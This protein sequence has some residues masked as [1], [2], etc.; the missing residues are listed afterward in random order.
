MAYCS[1]CGFQ[2]AGKVAFC[3][4][5]GTAVNKPAQ[6]KSAESSGKSSSIQSVSDSIT[7][8]LGLDRIDSFSLSKF[9]SEVF[10]KHDPAEVERLISVGTAETTPPLNAAMGVMPN[11]WIFFRALCGTIIAYLIFVIAWNSYH[12]LN[13]VPGLIVIGSLAVPF[14]ILILFF[15]LNTP[16]N[17]SIVRIVQLFLIGGAISLL[18]TLILFAQW[19]F[20]VTAFGASAA[21]IIEEIGK[22]AALLF[23]IRKVDINR[24]QYRL[25]AL[26]LGAAVGAGFAAFESAGYA[27]RVGLQMGPAAMLDMIMFRGILAPFMHI[28]WTAI[29][30]SAFWIARRHHNT[31]FQTV[32][33]AQFLKLFAIPVV[34]HFVWNYNLPFQLN[35]FVKAGILGFIAW[36]VILSLVQSGLRE[37]S[38]LTT[39]ADTDEVETE[40]SVAS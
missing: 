39:P 28:A 9:F 5:C 32:T 12:N 22:L 13:L 33:S 11:P 1:E 14:S 19:N 7:G 35:I 31:V 29:A 37:M 10:R 40:T 30:V 24:Y 21:G 25:N 8:K 38:E 26:L 3:S 36:V 23:V 16:R 15:E 2:L 4:Q 27:F 20:L 18:L 34:L 17:I 6:A